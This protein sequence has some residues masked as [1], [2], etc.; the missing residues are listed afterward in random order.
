MNNLMDKLDNTNINKYN[1]FGL[2]EIC[3]YNR[4][5]FMNYNRM[6]RD[7]LLVYVKNKINDDENIIN[8]PPFIYNNYKCY[9]KYKINQ[10]I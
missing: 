5:I 3:R 7:E 10:V 2:K 9:M 1:M 6:G 4:N 8:I